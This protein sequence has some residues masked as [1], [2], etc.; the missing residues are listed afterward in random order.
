MFNKILKNGFKNCSK[1]LLFRTDFEIDYQKRALVCNLAWAYTKK[2][3]P[4]P[5]LMCSISLIIQLIWSLLQTEWDKSD[6]IGLRQMIFI[7]KLKS[8]WFFLIGKSLSKRTKGK[9]VVCLESETE[10]TE[11]KRESSNSPNKK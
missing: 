5:F 6:W 1:K 3:T 4:T 9:S 2:F 7:F 11:H 10:H 8:N